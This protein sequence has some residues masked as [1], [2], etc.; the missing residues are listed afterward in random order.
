MAVLLERRTTFSGTVIPACPEFFGYEGPL[1]NRRSG[2]DL[3]DDQGLGRFAVGAFGEDRAAGSCEWFLG[4]VS[5]EG[6]G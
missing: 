3:D 4:D 1:G 6:A 5:P 2:I